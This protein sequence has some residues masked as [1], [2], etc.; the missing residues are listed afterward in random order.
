MFT[1]DS[2]G[3]FW[4]RGTKIGLVYTLIA[5]VWFGVTMTQDPDGPYGWLETWAILVALLPIAAASHGY[6]IAER[7]QIR[8]QADKTTSR[9]QNGGT[10]SGERKPPMTWVLRS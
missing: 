8:N 7:A 9:D 1:P 10:R 2:V 5:F 6:A 4:H 3:R